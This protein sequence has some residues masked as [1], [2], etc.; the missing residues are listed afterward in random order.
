M[1][2]EIGQLKPK[3]V[4]TINKNEQINNA[5]SMI[6][7][8]GG[9]KGYN[10]KIK[11]MK[12]VENAEYLMNLL[13]TYI[14]TVKSGGTIKKQRH[15]PYKIAAGGRYGNL[16]ILMPRLLTYGD[17]KAFRG[18]RLVM[19]KSID[20]DT[21]ELLTK[22]FNLRKHYSGTAKQIFKELTKLRGLPE[23][24]LSLKFPLL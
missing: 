16:R 2:A 23:N 1:L 10:L 5:E 6:K 20:N 24:R 9:I 8:I 12:A 15:I 18:G 11:N 13:R 4:T 19:D 7:K 22:K 17:L 21:M 14:D 3:D